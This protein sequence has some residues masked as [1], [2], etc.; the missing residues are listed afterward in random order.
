MPAQAQRPKYRPVPAAFF[1]FIK[2]EES[3]ELRVYDDKQPKLLLRAGDERKVVGRL[4]GGFGHTGAD[5][6]LGM[7][8]THMLADSWLRSDA[9]HKAQIPLAAK[10]GDVVWDLTDNQYAALLSFVYNLGTG[11]PNKPEWAIWRILRKRQ[12]DQ[13]PLQLDKFVNW[14]GKK[15]TG[16][17][18]RRNAE[19]ALWATGEPGTTDEL[20]PSSVLRREDTPPTVADPTPIH[21]N[22]TIIASAIAAVTGIPKAVETI[23]NT[24]TPFAARSEYVTHALE[25]AAT[26]GAGAAVLALGFA[27]L[28][29][30][31]QRT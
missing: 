23:T 6:V 30:R 8:V 17:V 12:F 24:I 14:D 4:T 26:V 19:K 10:I 20:P 7:T 22:P 9:E 18:N 11:N 5:L 21:K 27:W 13:V 31:Q 3:C 29:S 1:T 16:L 15:S 28:K 25:W 2:R